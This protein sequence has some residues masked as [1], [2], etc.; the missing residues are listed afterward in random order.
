MV[1][2]TGIERGIAALTAA[3]ESLTAAITSPATALAA[4]PTAVRKCGLC[5]NEIRAS[6]EHGF[7]DHVPGCLDSAIWLPLTK[8]GRCAAG[9]D[10]SI[11]AHARLG[12]GVL[13][14]RCEVPWGRILPQVEQ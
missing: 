4:P 2:L 14:C 11:G 12:C 8:D 13:G 7:S 6:V 9:C 1:D 3:I 10:H 5:R